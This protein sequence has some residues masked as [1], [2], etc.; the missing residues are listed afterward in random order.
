[1]YGRGGFLLFIGDDV[2]IDSWTPPPGEE[3][4]V[5]RVG[6]TRHLTDNALL[7]LRLEFVQGDGP[8]KVA[9]HWNTPAADAGVDEAVAT[10]RDADVIVFVGGLSAQLEGEEMQVDYEG[11]AGGDRL[12]IELPSLQRQLLEKLHATGKPVVFVNLAGSAIAMPWAD[13]NLNAIL[14]AWYPG[15]AGGAAVADVLLGRYN[16]AGRLPVT[17]YRSTADLPDF[18]NYEMAGRTY[19]YFQGQALYPFG[20]GL[21]YTTFRYANLAVS[22]AGEG[23]LAVTL[24]VTNTG[25]RDGDD[26][27]ATLCD[28]SRRRVLG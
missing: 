2:V 13:A 6:V 7:P 26:V 24:D 25:E 10:A 23:R 20:H 21:S 1:M 14:Q 19:R 11:F 4:Q 8:V 12:A 16:P 18:N 22:T 28:A 3:G 9:L 17:F 27:V 15:Q 5:R